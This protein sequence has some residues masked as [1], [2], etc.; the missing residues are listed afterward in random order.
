MQHARTILQ[1][2]YLRAEIDSSFANTLKQLE[3]NLSLTKQLNLF[4]NVRDIQVVSDFLLQVKVPCGKAVEESKPCDSFDDFLDTLTLTDE[5]LNVHFSFPLSAKSFRD[6]VPLPWSDCRRFFEELWEGLD[7]YECGS[8][9]T[10]WQRQTVV[11]PAPTFNDPNSFLHAVDK[12]QAL[13][14]FRRTRDVLIARYGSLDAAL[15]HAPFYPERHMLKEDRG[16]FAAWVDEIPLFLDCIRPT[17]V[18]SFFHAHQSDPASGESH[19]KLKSDSKRVT[20][21]RE[22]RRSVFTPRS[23]KETEEQSGGD[24]VVFPKSVA[25]SHPSPDPEEENTNIFFTLPARAIIHNDKKITPRARQPPVG[26]KIIPGAALL[27]K[28]TEKSSRAGQSGKIAAPKGQ[29]KEIRKIFAPKGQREEKKES[30]QIFAGVGQKEGVGQRE[31]KREIGKMSSGQ[32]EEKK[33]EEQDKT[34]KNEPGKKAEKEQEKVSTENPA[35][36]S[37]RGDVLWKR[38][39]LAFGGNFK[40]IQLAMCRTQ[41]LFDKV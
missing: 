17:T 11:Q 19:D 13:Q 24:T 26:K 7:V 36:H 10:A 1:K 15:K 16:I 14:S 34:E 41:D 33:E 8:F 37:L 29:R 21:H 31:E 40:E 32:R 30:G 38:I 35:L 20:S 25:L 27:S 23:E 39:L 4:V 6:T 2:W 3:H 12:A 5:G 18:G 28:E 9:E 22:V